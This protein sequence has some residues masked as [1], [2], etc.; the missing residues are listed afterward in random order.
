MKSFARYSHI[1]QIRLD[2][3]LTENSTIYLLNNQTILNIMNAQFQPDEYMLMSIS[4][5]FEIDKSLELIKKKYSRTRLLLLVNAPT[6]RRVV[7]FFSIILIRIHR[8]A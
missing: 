8:I 1:H 5:S 2:L 7:M 3:D 6:V 4:R